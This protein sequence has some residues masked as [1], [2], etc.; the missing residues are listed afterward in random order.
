ML[1]HS[2]SALT[3]VSWSTSEV[4]TA[5]AT[6]VLSR[7]PVFFKVCATLGDGLVLGQTPNPSPQITLSPL[8][9]LRCFARP[10]QALAFNPTP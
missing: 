2:I 3:M 4:R 7:K 1:S 9:T 5:N 8:P 6:P 10:K